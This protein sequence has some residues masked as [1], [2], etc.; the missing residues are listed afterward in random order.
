M[1]RSFFLFLALAAAILAIR[2]PAFAVPPAQLLRVEQNTPFQGMCCFSWREKVSVTEPAT[3]VPVIVTFSTDYQATTEF[4]VSVAVND[5]PCITQGPV[6]FDPFGTGDGSGPFDAHTFQW[7]ILPGQG[8]VKGK[9]T[10][11]LCG[12]SFS[13]PNGVLMLGFNTLSV[14]LS[15]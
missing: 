7:V 1:Q 13:Q 15:K 6:V 5:G 11:L 3:I 8:L 4:V 9:N 2:T 12:G 10:F 14:R